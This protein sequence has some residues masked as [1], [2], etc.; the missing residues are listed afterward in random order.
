PRKSL[1][2]AAVGSIVR[3]PQS[4]TERSKAMILFLVFI[5][6]PLLTIFLIRYGSPSIT[7]AFYRAGPSEERTNILKQGCQFG[8][9]LGAFFLGL[10]LF[11]NVIQLPPVLESLIDHLFAPV[12]L[13]I[14][15]VTLVI[16]GFRARRLAPK[17]KTQA[18]RSRRQ[19]AQ[20]PSFAL[21]P[22]VTHPPT[23]SLS[24]TSIQP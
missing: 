17:A 12:I 4:T 21:P 13:G 7:E 16:P 1:P 24:A 18:R 8:L 6:L 20:T 9:P 14:T 2:F 3:S 11:G 22:P 19:Q 5:S 15:V 10:A 23:E